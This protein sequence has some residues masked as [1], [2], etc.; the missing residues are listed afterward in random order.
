MSNN[1]N[2]L[3]ATMLS[4]AILLG[5]TWF[6]EKPRAE[7]K[8]IAQRIF[9]E[10]Q[11]LEKQKI[12]AEK[13]SESLKVKASDGIDLKIS[14]TKN[15]VLALKDRQQILEASQKDRVKISNGE[16]HGSISLKGARF[17][18]LTL[19][20]YF[21]EADKKEEVTLFAPSDSKERYFADFGWISSDNALE[22]PK[23]TGF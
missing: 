16:L 7:K 18:D 2:I 1:K 15:I 8:E 11:K 3:I 19:A 21:K 14:D 20:K 10:Q 9:V 4:M 5:W 12:I 22:L 17:D 6:Y 23:P 13:N